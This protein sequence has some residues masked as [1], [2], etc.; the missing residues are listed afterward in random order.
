MTIKEAVEIL[1]KEKECIRRVVDGTCREQGCEQCDVQ[2]DIVKEF[3]AYQMAIMA[4]KAICQLDEEA[5]RLASEGG[6]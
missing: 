1:E 6:Q 2:M 5:K 4:M 3:E